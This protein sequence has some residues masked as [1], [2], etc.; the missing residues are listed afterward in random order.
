M[1]DAII[2]FPRMKVAVATRGDQ[3]TGIHY[4]P[5]ATKTKA[6]TTPLAERA[7]QQLERY[8]ENPDTSFDLVT[9]RFGVSDVVPVKVRC[10]V[11]C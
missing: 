5:P 6:P 10:G 1:Y 11:G 3:V 8:R 7:V 9:S 4:L 2:E